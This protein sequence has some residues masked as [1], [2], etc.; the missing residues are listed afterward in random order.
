MKKNIIVVSAIALLCGGLWACGGN[1]TAKA[2]E[3]TA[4]E[5]ATLTYSTER[6]GDETASAEFPVDENGYIVI[7]DGSGTTGWRGYGRDHKPERWLVEDSCLHFVRGEGEGGDI[8]F[9]H[10]FDNFDVT[11]EWKVS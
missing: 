9:A 4:P 10:K 1:K 6:F 8:M 11:F 3:E 7:F 2:A 5:M